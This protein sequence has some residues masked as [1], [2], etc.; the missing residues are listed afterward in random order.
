MKPTAPQRNDLRNEPRSAITVQA[1]SRER[2]AAF[3]R[4][5]LTTGAATRDPVTGD[6]PRIL[7]RPLLPERR[8][9]VDM[10]L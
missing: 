5:L 6:R 8:F 4:G 1:L 3:G 2:R 7:P 10:Y 9:G